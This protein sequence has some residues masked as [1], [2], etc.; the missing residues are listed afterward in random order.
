MTDNLSHAWR[1]VLLT[2]IMPK[3]RLLDD[4]HRAGY[5]C[6][7]DVLDAEPDD[8]V[9]DVKGIGLKRAIA[10]RQKVF[11][12]LRLNLIREPEWRIVEPDHRPSFRASDFITTICIF[13]VIALM[14]YIIS[15][16]LV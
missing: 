15:Q 3:S 14:V 11:D 2:E 1:Y 10:I 13:A 8:L 12:A 7:G 9:A 4:L 6:A 16:L 5:H